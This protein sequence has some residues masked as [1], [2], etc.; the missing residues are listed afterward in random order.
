MTSLSSWWRC[1]HPH[2]VCIRGIGGAVSMPMYGWV[3]C[4][5]PAPVWSCQVDALWCWGQPQVGRTASS[6]RTHARHSRDAAPATHARMQHARGSMHAPCSLPPLLTRT[7]A[8]FLAVGGVHS[9]G[10]GGSGSSPSS[11][12]SAGGDSIS[13]VSPSAASSGRV[14]VSITMPRFLLASC[15]CVAS[16]CVAVVAGGGCRWRVEARGVSYRL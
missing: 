4:M 15:V 16:V 13:S 3:S 12:K 10:S 9:K 11:S 8:H 7:T 14:S 1:E 5:T 2:T 6:A